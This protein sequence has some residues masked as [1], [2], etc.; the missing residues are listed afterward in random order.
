MRLLAT[1]R[2]ILTG[3]ALLAL[4]RPAFAANPCFTPRVLFVCPMGSVKSAIAREKLR[5]EAKMR[6]FAVD[7]HS[8]GV[9][10]A[11][12]ISPGLAAHLKEEG[13]DP[14]ADPLRKFTK[15]DADHA[16]IVIAFDEAAMAPG[17]EH[18]RK[19]HSPSWN[20]D[21]ARAKAVMDAR[22]P[23]LA[24]ELARRSC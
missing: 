7:A 19:W 17:L 11:L 12:D 5:R 13:I 22:I 21:Y 24:D 18:A 2:D 6:G 3:L 1:R 23:A 4:P 9:N 16:D 20:D 8:R 15:A 10:P 14:L